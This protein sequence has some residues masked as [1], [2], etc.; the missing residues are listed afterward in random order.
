MRTWL[1]EQFE[2]D[3]P[4]VCAPMA[5]AAGGRLAAA[6]SA[7]GGLGMIGVGISAELDWLAEQMAIAAAPGRSWGVGLTGWA[8][9]E[10]D[11]LMAAIL[12][13][14]P[15][16][17]SI[18][19]GNVTEYVAPLH[20]AGIVVATQAG[21]IDDAFAADAVGVDLIVA[22]GCEGGGHGRNE[23][24]TLPLLQEIL[25]TVDAPVLGAGGISG[26][27]G[28]A[29]VIA[30]GAEG[31]WVGTAFS[32]CPESDFSAEAKHAVL[33]AR[34]TDTVYSRVFDL[35]LGSGWPAEFGGRS[36]VNEVTRRWVGRQDDLAAGGPAVTALGDQ[37]RSARDAGDASFSA[38][39]AGQGAGLV[40]T[41]RPAA[42]VVAE[43]GAI[44]DLLARLR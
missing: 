35:A 26:R 22:R 30:A 1:T 38:V 27:R 7:A 19:F 14:K 33:E 24:A 34:T 23:V 4:I 25:E 9:Q 40:E 12:R 2:L 37:L 15:S 18:S 11:E 42:E 3:V 17:V 43:F 31:A 44:E 6:V 16:L 41:S 20:D 32:T 36:L 29:A 28:L 10:G 13:A 21:T 39:Y 8:V 5:G